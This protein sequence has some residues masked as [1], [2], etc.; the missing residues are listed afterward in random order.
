M[1]GDRAHD[2]VVSE[3]NAMQG[4]LR[5][6][7]PLEA[8]DA[9]DTVT[10]TEG[11]VSVR[12]S[13]LGER[14]SRLEQDL[15]RV[16]ARID[17]DVPERYTVVEWRHFPEFNFAPQVFQLTLDDQIALLQGTIAERLEREG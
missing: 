8:D 9:L 2:E 6:V 17:Q 15:A 7:E 16:D 1:N 14:I 4:R 13:A 5:G 11:D 10:V 3:L 12:M